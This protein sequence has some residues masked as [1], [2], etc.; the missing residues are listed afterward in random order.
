MKAMSILRSSLLPLA[1]L[2][3]PTLS[4][5]AENQGGASAAAFW[6][7]K[8]YTLDDLRSAFD[9]LDRS[10]IYSLLSRSQL[11]MMPD[12][13][14]DSVRKASKILDPESKLP[15]H[16]LYVY[17]DLG[18]GDRWG[19]HDK[20][21]FDQSLESYVFDQV[22]PSWTKARAG[23]G[24]EENTDGQGLVKPGIIENADDLGW[25][26][27]MLSIDILNTRIRLGR[28]TALIKFQQVVDGKGGDYSLD[29]V[30]G[31]IKSG[32]E[33]GI[34]TFARDGE[35]ELVVI[36]NA[37]RMAFYWTMMVKPDAS[38]DEQDRKKILEP[39]LAEIMYN[40]FVIPLTTDVEVRTL[41]G[42]KDKCN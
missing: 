10:I 18:K 21:R 28:K 9:S 3:V 19:D 33:S 13:E 6:S 26:N 24:Q 2:V 12:N 36:Q 17:Q 40:G 32:D 7:H 38:F 4:A 29:R 37:R 11:G 35:R 20:L 31:M 25:L 16:P 30:C 42:L 23:N 15:G 27:S 1:L 5:P 22:V 14:K 41:M 8:D 39:S 34:R